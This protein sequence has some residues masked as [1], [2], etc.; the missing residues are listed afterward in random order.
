MLT[1]WEDEIPQDVAHL[2]IRSR[3]VAPG[4]DRVNPL[5]SRCPFDGCEATFSNASDFDRHVTV[6]KH[7]KKKQGDA[8]N[9]LSRGRHTRVL[10]KKEGN[11]MV[12]LLT[13]GVMI[14]DK[15]F[16]FKSMRY[17]GKLEVCCI[18]AIV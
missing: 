8:K 14:C 11:E 10:Y 3:W 6:Q 12:I 7:P 18:Y 4:P 9:W 17:F 13:V 2:N 15:P 1:E 16:T 5:W